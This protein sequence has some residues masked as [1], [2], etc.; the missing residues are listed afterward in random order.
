VNLQFRSIA[1]SPTKPARRLFTTENFRWTKYF[2]DKRTAA[3][4]AGRLA[5]FDKFRKKRVDRFLPRQLFL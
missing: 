1:K 2:C 5:A 3:S 4:L